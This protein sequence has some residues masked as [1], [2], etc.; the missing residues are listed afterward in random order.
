MPIICASSVIPF[1]APSEA[2]SGECSF[3]R[4]ITSLTELSAL[5]PSHAHEQITH[6]KAMH[7]TLLRKSTVE[8]AAHIST[9]CP[10][11]RLDPSERAS[12]LRSGS[13]VNVMGQARREIRNTVSVLHLV[14]I[15]GSES[16]SGIEIRPIVESAIPIFAGCG[17]SVGND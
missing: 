16:L 1:A 6:P 7:P 4:S 12:T 13:A 10:A 11:D 15:N 5:R 9:S 8:I 14:R 3:T 2:G 17:G